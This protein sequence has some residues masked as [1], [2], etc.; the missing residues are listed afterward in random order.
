M[1]DDV[2]D[3]IKAADLAIC[4]QE[5]PISA[6]N[7]N[8]TVPNTLSF[9]APKEIATALKNAG[10]DGCDTASNHTWD[11]RLTGVNQ[12]LDVLDAA[13]LKHA[14]SARIQAEA[15]T[16]P[17]YDVNGRQGRPPRVQLRHL[18]HRRARHEGAA[19]R[20]VAEDDAVAGASGPRASSPRPRPS[21]RAAPS[22]SS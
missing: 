7:K 20:A 1:F 5:T 4:H 17:I 10:F 2:R 16:P 18:Q 22:S 8:L 11:R 14:G 12:T 21:R 9:N 6:D 15:D 19:R 13:G 3:I